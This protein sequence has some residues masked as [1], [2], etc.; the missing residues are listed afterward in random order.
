[1]AVPLLSLWGLA[2]PKTEPAKSRHCPLL[3]DRG[4]FWLVKAGTPASPCHPAMPFHVSRRHPPAPCVCVY[5][6]VLFNFHLL[7]TALAP[8]TL[9]SHLITRV[10]SELEYTEVEARRKRP[11]KERKEGEKKATKSIRIKTLSSGAGGSLISQLQSAGLRA[12]NNQQ[13]L[14][15]SENMTAFQVAKP[16]R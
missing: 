9:L 13:N 11:K 1:M 8:A 6:C 15:F 7:C 12:L 2:S 4:Q 10:P 14:S 16:V 3:V 5:V